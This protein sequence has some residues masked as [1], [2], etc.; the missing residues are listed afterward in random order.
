M[1]IKT[2]SIKEQL[3]SLAELQQADTA[4][5]AIDKELSGVQDRIDF[6]ESDLA[7]IRTQMEEKKK[8]LEELKKEYRSEEMEV[9]RIEDGISRS[10]AKLHSVKTNKEYQSM[11]KEMDVSRHK[12]SDM[13][14]NM[15]TMLDRIEAGEK[16]AAGLSS[17]F[18]VVQAEVVEKKA[19]I[20]RHSEALRQ[21]RIDLHNEREAIW[22]DLPPKLQTMYARAIQQG[23]GIGVTAVIDAVCQSCRMNIPPQQ[24]IELIRLNSM[25]LCPNC[26]RIIFPDTI[27]QGK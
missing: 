5:A 16:E 2:T 22:R 19:E 27:W 17:D 13:Q 9:K 1:D 23:R 8:N 21:K 3:A 18:T 26:Q 15:L 24:Y 11:L 10:E 14:D 6:L 4:I 7:S 12:I 20:E 25:K